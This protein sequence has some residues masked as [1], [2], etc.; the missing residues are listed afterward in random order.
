[1]LS[2][3]ISQFKI[4]DYKLNKMVAASWEIDSG[5]AWEIKGTVTPINVK[6][7]NLINKVPISGK[8]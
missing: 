1:M 6:C 5:S 3:V 4:I 8:N 2:N 7:L